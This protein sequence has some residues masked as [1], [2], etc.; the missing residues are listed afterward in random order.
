MRPATSAV[1]VLAVFGGCNEPSVF[2]KTNAFEVPD[3]DPE[4]PDFGTWLSLDVAPEGQRLVATYYDRQAEGLGFAVGYPNGKDE[5]EWLHEQV[6]GYTSP[7]GGL[8]PQAGKYGSMRVAPDGTVWVSY[9]DEGNDALKFAHRLGGGPAAIEAKYSWVTGTID[10]G[11]G[12]GTWTSLDLDAEGKP[13]VAYHDEANGTLKIA[14]LVEDGGSTG[15]TVWNTTVA[16]TGNA[17]QGVDADG[18]AVNRA[19]D[20]GEHARLLIREGTYLIAYHDKAQRALGLAEGPKGGPFSAS[21]ISASAAC[22]ENGQWPSILITQAG[23]PTIAYHDVTNQN[24][25][26]A[27]R[28][29][30]AWQPPELVDA[31]PYVGADTEVVERLGTVG[32]VYFDGQ[33]NDMK[34]ASK[35]GNGAVWVS[36]T[37]GGLDAPVGFHNEIVRTG[38]DWWAA[39][40]DYRSRKLFVTQLAVQKQ[41]P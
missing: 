2:D 5:L 19:A 33:N 39:S 18:K 41:Q 31:A 24:L 21:L 29:S 8:I 17:F 13:V 9:W 36:E 38:N 35:P 26:I 11:P 15:E 27:T 37:L 25:C 20:V 22:T 16:V 32:I 1:L 28:Q 23:V 34:Y 30:G 4:P 10:E 12:V 3:P 14:Y 40:Y 6:D 7:D